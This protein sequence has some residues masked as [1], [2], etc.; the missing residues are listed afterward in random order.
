VQSH[1]TAQPTHSSLTHGVTLSCINHNHHMSIICHLPHLLSIIYHQYCLCHC[2]KPPIDHDTMMTI[3]KHQ[4][5][6][7]QHQHCLLQMN[8]VAISSTP[9]ATMNSKL[10]TGSP[11]QKKSNKITNI[12]SFPSRHWA[13]QAFSYNNYSTSPLFLC[14]HLLL[15][16]AEP[17]AALSQ[18]CFKLM[19][20][21]VPHDSTNWQ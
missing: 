20:C 11:P 18:R 12:R 10:K 13:G 19:L 6:G 16:S 9:R 7:K 14:I 2:S 8:W 21:Y 17:V 1:H 4:L 3:T 15:Q 5:L